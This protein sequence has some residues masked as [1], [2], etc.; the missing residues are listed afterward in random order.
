M[1][2]QSVV[3][4]RS[5]MIRVSE[6][7]D[8][9]QLECS[10]AASR[11]AGYSV[12]VF[13]VRGVMMDCGFPTIGAELDR[14]LDANPV[15]GAIL[16]HAHEDHAGNADRLIAR[17]LPVHM[18]D[19]SEAA[20]RNPGHIGWYRRICWGNVQPMRGTRTPF[21]DPTF[22]LEPAPG[23][24]PDH[25]VIWD[26]ERE[27]YFCGDAFIGVKVRVAHLD[28]DLGAHVRTLRAMA[29]RKPKRVF[30]GHR[31]LLDDPVQ[32]LRAKA[33]WIE[34]TVHHIETLAGRGWS[35]QRIRREVLGPEDL[36]GW[37]SFGDYSRINFVRLVL[38]DMDVR[39]NPTPVPAAP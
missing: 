15:R 19:A 26:P 6:H 12:N 10:T 35:P 23:H 25:H 31:G 4:Y 5:A 29:A 13:V 34:E 17:G 9:R 20:A 37:M 38:S 36:T 16:T 2:V 14:W 11:A 8:V 21:S 22:R 18:A 1:R 33:D 3:G 39:R 32:T 28:E 7:D 27:T 30:D 24:S